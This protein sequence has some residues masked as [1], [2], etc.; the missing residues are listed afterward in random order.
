MPMQARII[1]LYECKNCVVRA[2]DK[3]KMVI[4][5]LDGYTVAE[6]EWTAACML[7]EKGTEN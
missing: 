4:Q 7:I 1:R 3:G 6:K 2:T 5:A